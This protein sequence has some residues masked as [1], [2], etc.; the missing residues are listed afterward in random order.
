MC[1]AV[2]YCDILYRSSGRISLD[3]NIFT[4]FF[5][6]YYITF[7][8]SIWFIFCAIMSIFKKI[9]SYPVLFL[10]RFVGWYRRTTASRR[11]SRCLRWNVSGSW[12]GKTASSPW[13]NPPLPP[14]G[15]YSLY[16]YPHSLYPPSLY[17]SFL[18]PTIRPPSLSPPCNPSVWI[19]VVNMKF[20]Y[21]AL[22][23]RDWALNR[24]VD[25]N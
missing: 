7:G 3:A 2:L 16:L 18:H 19:K 9:L 1:C 14:C 17:P 24:L 25:T 22:F 21:I 13:S 23:S 15:R 11:T 4:I 10:L 20:L 5:L 12:R 6:T 8:W